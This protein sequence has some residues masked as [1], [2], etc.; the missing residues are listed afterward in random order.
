MDEAKTQAAAAT[1]TTAGPTADGTRAA[2]TAPAAG[3]GTGIAAGEEAAASAQG[4]TGGPEPARPTAAARAGEDNGPWREA[5]GVPDVKA[6]TFG[7][8][9]A[10]LAAGWS[11]FLAA[12][13]FGIGVGLVYAVF[14]WLL[15]AVAESATLDGLTFPLFGGF[16][17]V[18]P[19]AATIL[20]EISRRRSI[21]LSFSLSDAWAII[22][23]TARRSL[24]ILGLVLVLW[25]GIWS[26][27][28]VFIYAIYYGFDA[29]PFLEMLPDLV[30]T[31]R[32][33]LFL[34]WG[35]V[36]G[37]GFAA[38]A[39]CMS[40]LSFPFLLDRDADI[41]TAI[42]TSFKAVLASPVVMLSWAAIIGIVMAI[43]A[44]PAFLGFLVALPLF[45]HATWHLYRRL[46]LT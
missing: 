21:G 42:I 6:A 4:P 12:P 45:G 25:L 17:M 27:A 2:G 9:G 20:Y 5:T 10:A 44:V 40:A 3:T 15:L 19:F 34:F 1:R 22:G 37:A 13:L 35:H 41:A 31:E 11:D 36:V 46:V 30:T 7:D 26:R 32:G 38:V 24:M 29:P 23:G 18:A 39:Y 28:A 8:L 16:V 43:A 33:L 14:G